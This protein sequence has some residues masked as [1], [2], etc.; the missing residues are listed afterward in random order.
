MTKNW[1][2]TKCFALNEPHNT[3]CRICGENNPNMDLPN[4]LRGPDV[5]QA[6]RELKE[7]KE[8]LRSGGPR[9]RMKRKA[10]ER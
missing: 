9:T 3:V 6:V 8:F 5:D 2:C 7:L 4:E 10:K 1:T